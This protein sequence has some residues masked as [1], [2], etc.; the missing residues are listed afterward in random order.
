V[1]TLSKDEIIRGVRLK[2]SSVI[3]YLYREY[4]PVILNYIHNNHGSTNDAEDVFQE[5]LVAIYRNIRDEKEEKIRDFDGYIFGISSFIWKKKLRDRSVIDEISFNEDSH[6]LFLDEIEKTE[7]ENNLQIAIYQKHFMSLEEELQKV[8]RL[9]FAKIPM[10][11]IAKVMGYSS[12]DY[13]KKRKY[14]AQ[15]TLIS[16]IR[17]DP[18]FSEYE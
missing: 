17:S 8:L 16:K 7:I 13:A 3:K 2:D 4:F 12:E 9:Y 11:E 1:K 5:T 15:R 14:I 6:D 18:D 10:K